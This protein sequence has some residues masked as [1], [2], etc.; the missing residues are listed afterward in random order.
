[1]TTPFRGDEVAYDW[2]AENLSRYSR[3]GLCGFLILGSNGEAVHLSH[4][5][6]LRVM[7]V[8]REVIP[9]DKWMMVGAG[10]HS[11]AATLSMTREASK[12]GADCVLV[13]PPHYYRAAMK[14]ETLL[15][16]YFAV[17][18]GSPVPVF[19]YNV[20]QF[21]GLNLEPHLVAKMAQHPN[22][23]GIKDSS[24]NI[25]QLA[26]I[27]RL[28]PPEFVVLVGNALVFL[29]ALAMGAT[30]GILA[31]SNVLPDAFVRVYRL[32]MEGRWDEARGIQLE[33]LA[34]SKAVTVQYGIG[35]LKA[36]M[37]MAGYRGGEVRPPL[38]MP[39]EEAMERLR[40]MVNPWLQSRG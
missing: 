12:V 15:R 13:S 28:T 40:S 33:L 19:I 7:E 18:D 2:L 26:E 32:A 27:R 10:R 38:R 5:E 25:A 35:G 11:T 29:A 20:P 22:I 1:V 30:G 24:G 36:A 21:T 8:A 14:E 3:T 39:D 23:R 4:E 31:A 17:A 6:H 37:D 34:I 9:A 16:H